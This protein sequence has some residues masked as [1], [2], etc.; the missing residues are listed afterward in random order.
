M[1]PSP[2]FQSVHIHHIGELAHDTHLR[3]KNKCNIID[4]EQKLE[5]DK[6]NDELRDSH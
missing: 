5:D 6:L 1:F 2:V 3:L 4:S